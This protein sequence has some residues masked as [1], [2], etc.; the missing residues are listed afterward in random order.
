MSMRQFGPVLRAAAAEARGVLLQMAAER[1]Q[2]PVDR[3]RVKAGRRQRQRR[4]RR[5]ASPTA[6]LTEGKRIERHL[7]TSRR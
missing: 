7:E 2:V 1:L 3:L 6:Q 5:S 4:R